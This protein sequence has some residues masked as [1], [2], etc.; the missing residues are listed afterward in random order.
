[1][2]TR[3]LSH[4]A[5]P[6]PQCDYREDDVP[7]CNS[8]ATWMVRVEDPTGELVLFLCRPHAFWPLAKALAWKQPVHATPLAEV[9]P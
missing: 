6:S 4:S 2:A 8:L 1:M 5:L 7:R 3:N 9:R